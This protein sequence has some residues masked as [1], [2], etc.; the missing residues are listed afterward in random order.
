MLFNGVETQER[1]IRLGVGPYLS[2]DAFKGVK[3]RINLFST[4]NVHL[5]NQVTIT[6]K[7]NASLDQRDFRTITLSPK[8]GLQY[9]RKKI[10][11]D[12]DFVISTS[13]EMEPATTFRS[14]SAANQVDWWDGRG[15]DKF[16]TR[17]TFALGGLIGLQSAY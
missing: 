3:N 7:N 2:Y 6:Q 16:K 10:L 9:H 12:V 4:I 1:G 11:E 15:N 14:N 5:F 8:I 17:A 13:F